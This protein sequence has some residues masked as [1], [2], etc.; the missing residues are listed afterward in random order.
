MKPRWRVGFEAFQTLRR[1]QGG[2]SLR[3]DQLH[4]RAKTAGLKAPAARETA[5]VEAKDTRPPAARTDEEA[6]AAAVWEAT[7]RQAHNEFGVAKRDGRG[8]R[9]RADRA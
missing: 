6:P 2:A 3:P 4:A 5:I 8:F 9:V 7:L 1:E